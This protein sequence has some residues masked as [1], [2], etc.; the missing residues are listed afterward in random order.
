MQGEFRLS[1]TEFSCTP[2]PRHSRSS[3]FRLQ[4]AGT[5]YILAPESWRPGVKR[6]AWQAADAARDRLRLSLRLFHIPVNA[7]MSSHVTR[8]GHFAIWRSEFRQPCSI[9]VDGQRRCHN[10]SSS[11]LCQPALQSVQDFPVS[12]TQFMF[13]LVLSRFGP[14]TCSFCKNLVVRNRI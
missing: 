5:P 13:L 8:L 6:S 2:V 4:N 11:L 3:A 14:L 12:C 10:V 1:M 9:P 7:A